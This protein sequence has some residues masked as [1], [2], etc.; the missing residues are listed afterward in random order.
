MAVLDHWLHY[1]DTEE[2]LP[3]FSKPHKDYVTHKFSG[4]NWNDPAISQTAL[5]IARDSNL[6][7]IQTLSSLDEI[8][9]VL[10][11]LELCDDHQHVQSVYTA[12]LALEA[13]APQENAARSDFAQLLVR[14][15][16][17]APYLIPLFFL[18]KTWV[19][20]KEALQEVFVT[21]VPALLKE[22]V[23]A[24]ST[25]QYAICQSFHLLLHNLQQLS[26]PS[27]AELV[28]LIA[29]TISDSELAMDLLLDCLEPETERLLACSAT[30][31][32][33]LTKC[34]VGIAL[35]HIDMISG[36]KMPATSPIQL[37]LAGIG[38][39]G[40]QI[41]KVVLRLDAHRPAQ[42]G[43]HVRMR[44]SQPPQNAPHQNM[45]A[46]DAIVIGSD[47]DTTSLRCLHR[48]QSYAENCLWEIIGCRSFVSCKAEF[49]AVTLFYSQKVECCKIY[50]TLVGQSSDQIQLSQKPRPFKRDVTLNSSQNA[51]LEAAMSHYCTFIWAPP[52]TGRIRTMV[53]VLDQL[54]V[55]F[56]HMRI[57][58]AAPTP[59]AVDN[60]LRRYV[61]NQ[62]V[63]NT[64]VVPLR[65]STRVCFSPFHPRNEDIHVLSSATRGP[66]RYP[67][68]YV[69][70]H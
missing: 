4:V 28:E 48:L 42:V 3:L 60:I 36:D 61:A 8:R 12:L 32:E 6:S 34:L 22:L 5:G 54:Q 37:E 35:K 57:L 27:L 56:K 18:S 49:D 70:R 10:K 30:E 68:V 21:L 66:I 31:S 46:V 55:H 33:Q 13:N 15:L 7:M 23:L 62:S 67:E 43:D 17:T 25:F 16:R 51:A 19:R 41:I 65:F 53:A 52:G 1:I 59:D 2:I 26:I 58:V 29:L 64:G 14:F 38:L 50:A 47:G 69:R 9:Q 40:Y 44:P 63:T 24:G 45:S 11:L 39:D 20:Q